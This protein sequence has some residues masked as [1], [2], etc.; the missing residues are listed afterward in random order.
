MSSNIGHFY[1]TG[2]SNS[3]TPAARFLLV[4]L[5]IEAILEEVTI[6]KRRRKLEEMRKGKRLGDAYT[7]TLTR[8]KSQ[9]GNKSRLGMEALM[10]IS[11]SERPLKALELCQ[12]LGVE[13]GETDENSW[14]IP[15]IETVLRCSLGLIT[16]EASSSTVRLVHFTLQ[17]HLSNTSSL[18]DGPH[19]MMAE[20]CL[21]F[22]NFQR[23]RDLPTTLVSPPAPVSFVE[24]ASC[25]WGAHARKG[26]N[27]RAESL[28][29]RLLDGYD[30]HLSSKLLL[31]HG[32]DWW[33]HLSEKSGS[34]A[35]EGFTG[36]HGAAYLGIVGMISSLS[37]KR[38]WDVNST[39][40]GG[41]TPFAW[42]ARKGHEDAVRMLLARP[43]V[44]PD[45]ANADGRT[46]LMWAA[47]CGHK[48]VVEKLL[49]RTDV[50]PNRSDKFGQTA[51]SLAVGYGRREVVGILVKRMDID[52]N[53]IGRYGRTPLS[54]A[55]LNGNEGVVKILLDRVDIE[56][57]TEDANGLTP[58]SQAAWDGNEGVMMM[59]LGR[60]DVNPDTVNICG[61][62][63][64]SLA[65]T[66]GYERVVR[67]L[68]ERNEVNPNTPDKNGET[69]LFGA[70]RR[71]HGRVVKMLL[72]RLDVDPNTADKYGQTP[73]FGAAC[74][75]H[76]GVVKVLLERNDVNPNTTHK[77][78]TTPLSRA[79]WKGHEGV[80]KMLLERLDVDANTADEDG[81]V[82]RTVRGP[83]RDG[84]D[85]AK[86]TGRDGTANSGPV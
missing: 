74:R 85:N 73:L 32:R 28:A 50:N 44:D 78:G 22:L 15:A 63:L 36:L 1:N 16:I 45:T 18:F 54:C 25:Y 64:L 42:A 48:G 53:T 67:M 46:P 55:V 9:N 51:L 13:R 40:T 20:I 59:L 62:T 43:G 77:D 71:G 68:L 80:V 33:S 6:Y 8:I 34:N 47:A 39:D 29:L 12:A 5:H 10:W 21:T 58:L 30:K 84:G 70:A 19:S 56:P 81:P 86:K 52:P 49:E 27:P 14:N 17:E 57:D 3:L 76:G 31:I 7:A 37:E 4:S 82:F 72:E 26:L 11:Y 38:E 83:H 23:V 65:A 60:A 69:P 41:N 35:V 79:A 61:Q 2:K 24:Y 75:G 66:Y